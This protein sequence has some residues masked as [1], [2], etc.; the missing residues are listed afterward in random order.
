MTDIMSIL[1]SEQSYY[2]LLIF[3][4]IGSGYIYGLAKDK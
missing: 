2:L 4:G 1:G 3:A